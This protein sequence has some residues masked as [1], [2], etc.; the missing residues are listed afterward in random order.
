MTEEKIRKIIKCKP[1]ESIEERLELVMKLTEEKTREEISDILYKIRNYEIS[2]AI[3][4]ER[5][6]LASSVANNPEFVSYIMDTMTKIREDALINGSDDLLR[7]RLLAL[8]DIYKFFNTCKNM[9][10]KS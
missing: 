4:S 7:G 10:N 1:E 3:S 8:S 6:A 9:S 5:R 2:G